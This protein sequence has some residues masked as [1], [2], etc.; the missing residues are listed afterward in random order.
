MRIHNNLASLMKNRAIN[1]K[2]LSELAGIPCSEISE[3]V[4]GKRAYS[5]E[6]LEKICSALNVTVEQ[7]YPDDSMREALAE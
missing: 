3:G 7:I 4:N 5:D 2:R 1:G 6:Q